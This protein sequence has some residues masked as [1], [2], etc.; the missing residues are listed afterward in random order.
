MKKVYQQVM[1]VKMFITNHGN[2]SDKLAMDEVIN[3]IAELERRVLDMSK[4]IH[5]RELEQEPNHE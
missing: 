2:T 4:S 5:L 3:Y 1:R